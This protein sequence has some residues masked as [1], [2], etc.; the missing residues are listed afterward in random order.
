MVAQG[1]LRIVL[2]GLVIGSVFLLGSC[3]EVAPNSAPAARVPTEEP[4]VT[5]DPPVPT[6]TNDPPEQQ[7]AD[8]ATAGAR[9]SISSTPSGAHVTI[10]GGAGNARRLRC[11][12]RT[13][14]HASYHPPPTRRLHIH[15]YQARN[16][17][18]GG[19]CQGGT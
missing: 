11:G 13:H 19:H 16:W 5:D 9:V 10:D 18:S 17:R 1:I 15:H 6:E 12:C 8:P 7:P 4:P 2:G 14:Y 3:E